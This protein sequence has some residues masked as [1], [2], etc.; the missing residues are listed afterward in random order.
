MDQKIRK[1]EQKIRRNK[2][3]NKLHH[4]GQKDFWAAVKMAQN[5]P[6]NQIPEKMTT[7]NMKQMKI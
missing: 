2:I 3:Q 6:E 4:G 7:S 5:K 1:E